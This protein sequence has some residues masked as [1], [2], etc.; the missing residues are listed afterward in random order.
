MNDA[1]R[2]ASAAKGD[3]GLQSGA[4]MAEF[5]CPIC[6]KA[7]AG[8]ATDAD[9]LPKYFPFCSDRC[10]LVDLGRWLDGKYQV[11]AEVTDEQDDQPPD[12]A[13]GR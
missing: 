1:A 13:S 8:P 9:P 10:R 3:T 4:I 2:G 7:I 5:H 11:P 6:R 12:P